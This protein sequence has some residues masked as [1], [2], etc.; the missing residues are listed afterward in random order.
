[1]LPSSIARGAGRKPDWRFFSVA[2]GRPP[3]RAQDGTSTVTMCPTH[4]LRP[5]AIVRSLTHIFLFLFAPLSAAAADMLSS[6]APHPMKICV[7][8]EPCPA[9]Y[10]SGV[11][12]RIQILLK[13]LVAEAKN[14]VE[15]ITAEAVHP[16]PPSEWNGISI[17]YI[18]GIPLPNYP[19]FTLAV[20]YKAKLWRVIWKMRPD[21]IHCTSPGILTFPAIF[22]ARVLQIPIVTSYHTHL[23]VYVRTYLP[24]GIN[25]IAE[26]AVWR[27]LWA[28]HSLSDLTLVTS[29][30]ILEQFEQRRIP[31]CELWHKG[32]DS[33]KFSP[34]HYSN[35]MRSRMCNGCSNSFLLVYIGRLAKE[36]RLK[37]LRDIIAAVPNSRLA[38]VGKGPYEQELKE[39]FRNTPTVFTGELTGTE[40]SQAFASADCFVMPSD[41]ETLGFVVLESMASGVPVVGCAAGGIPDIIQNEET[42]FLVPPGDISAYVSRIL[43]IQRDSKLK[44]AI[45][46]AARNE[47]KR[48]DWNESMTKVCGSYSRARDNFSQRWERKLLRLLSSSRFADRISDYSC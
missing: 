23:P 26:W 22:C 37:E 31:R 48:W 28:I 16:N 44:T 47:M 35:E 45:S 7:I 18:G 43:Q 21:L 1:M 17:H 25:R 24:R 15:I 40:L 42:G 19:L 10:V 39:Y 12:A 30:P 5:L 6:C 20:D 32:V 27:L 4:S 3:V 14:D 33:I 36:K 9:T 38:F 11:S 46:E 13:H 29:S 2:R 41:S 34:D 8:T